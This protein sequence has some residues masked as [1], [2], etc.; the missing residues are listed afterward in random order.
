MAGFKFKFKCVCVCV[1][2]CVCLCVCAH[3]IN[4][5]VNVVGKTMNNLEI[6]FLCGS[7]ILV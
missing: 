1:C 2:V 4:V 7:Y 6:K 3:S 5:Y